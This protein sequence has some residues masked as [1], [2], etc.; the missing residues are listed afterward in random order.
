MRFRILAAAFLFSITACNYLMGQ[1]VGIGEPNPASKLSV[2]GGAAVGNDYSAIAAPNNGMII[3]GAVGIGTS[4]VDT[5]TVLDL[6][7][8]TKGFLLPKMNTTTRALFTSPPAGLMIYNTDSSSFNYF[9]GGT[10]RN[11]PYQGASGS[12]G[13][14]LSGTYPNPTVAKINGSL[15]GSTSPTTGK[16]LIANGIKWQSKSI[17][18]DVTI[19]SGGITTLASTAVTAAPYGSATQVG[20]FTVDAKGRLTAASNVTISGVAPGGT[21]GGDLSGTYPNPTVASINGASLGTTTATSGNLLIG[22]GA[23]WLSAAVSGDITLAKSGAATIGTNVVSNGKI[24]QSAGFSVIGNSASS[25]ANVADITGTS[26][27]VLRVN[28][29]GTALGFGTID[30]NAFGSQTANNVWI[31]PNGSSGI[32]TFRALVSADIPDLS[33]TYLKN[34]TS[35]QS[36]SN[37]N[38]SANGIIGGTLTLSPITAGSV[39]FAGASGVISQSNS[40][41]FWDNTNSR[42]GILT[43]SPTSSFS[44]GASNQFQVN[45]TGNIIK[46]NNVTT[47]FPSSQGAANSMLANDGSGNLSWTTSLI[48]TSITAGVT[49]VTNNVNNS[50]VTYTVLASD[51]L[52]LAAGTATGGAAGITVTLPNPAAGNTGRIIIVRANSVPA[53]TITTAG[54]TSCMEVS[55]GNSSVSSISIGSNAGTVGGGEGDESVVR[56][57]STGSTWIGW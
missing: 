23:Q 12:A 37:F 54:A 48:G 11:S 39:L 30:G 50:V 35:Q 13:G 51:F 25:T 22:Q 18:G 42:L 26:G 10:W 33:G 38:I 56:L 24:R 53:V 16:V 20:T 6:S 31:A 5:N 29:A 17:S 15:V 1:N 52:I 40:N 21:A 36:S 55:K 49:T 9:D 41:L 44:V 47:S 3:E 14:D 43:A 34:Q 4:V 19:D 57:I 7:H 45:S 27:Q 28:T 8:S 32:P 2:K 46:L